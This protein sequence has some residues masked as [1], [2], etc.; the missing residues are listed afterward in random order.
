VLPRDCIIGSIGAAYFTSESQDFL[1][2]RIV[3][4]RTRN[5]F[6]PALL[7]LT[8]AHPPLQ[9]GDLLFE[10]AHSLFETRHI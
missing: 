1:K 2:V 6:D 7:R 3:R 8:L 5:P 4:E 9:S 10:S